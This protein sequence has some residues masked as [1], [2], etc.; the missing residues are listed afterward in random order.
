LSV[1]IQETG[2]GGFIALGSTKG[3]GEESNF[4]LLNLMVEVGT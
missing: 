2:G 4:H 3:G 1:K